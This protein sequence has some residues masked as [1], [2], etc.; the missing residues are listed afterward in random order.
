MTEDTT[1]TAVRPEDNCPYVADGPTTLRCSKCNKPLMPKD[2][3]RT[4]TG[5]VCPYYIKARVATF[6]SAQPIH[7]VV[8]G[9]IAF[10]LGIAGGLA[11]RLVGTIGFFSIILTLF[12]APLIGGAVAE[13]IRRVLRKNRGQYF[14]LTAAVAFS[15][16]AAYFVLLPPI[17]LLLAGSPNFIWSL[18][19]AGGLV[20]AVSTM[21]ARMR[22]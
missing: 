19:P 6:Y 20:L 5:Y 3:K 1:T 2:A 4:P 16:G 10:G 13:V 9:A 7:Y 21:V 11:L 15:I 8:A 17:A 18:I 12:V 14:W 22:V